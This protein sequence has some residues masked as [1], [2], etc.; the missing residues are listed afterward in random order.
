MLMPLFTGKVARLFTSADLEQQLH[1]LCR[2]GPK[3]NPLKQLF[4]KGER[5]AVEKHAFVQV[6]NLSRWLVYICCIFHRDAA[7]QMLCNSTSW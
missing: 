2:G 3:G 5:T 4:F 1:P 7:F 6:S